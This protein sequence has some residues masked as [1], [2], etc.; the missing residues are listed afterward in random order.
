MTLPVYPDRKDSA[1]FTFHFQYFPPQKI[2]APTIII[3][4]GGPGVG[5]IDDWTNE[6]MNQFGLPSDAGKIF[7]DPRT[8]GCNEED[9]VVFPEDALTSEY[10]AQDILGMIRY[11]K[12]KNFILYGH[13]YGTVLATVTGSLGEKSGLKPS[14]LVLSGVIGKWIR[15]I[16]GTVF[17]G[18]ETEWKKLRKHIPASSLERFKSTPLPLGLSSNQWYNI[19]EE[20]LY[21]G[22]VMHRSELIHPLKESLKLLAHQ[23]VEMDLKAKDILIDHKIGIKEFNPD[24]V[25]FEKWSQRLFEVI[26]CGE[27]TDTEPMSELKN[28]EIVAYGDTCYQRQSLIRP[29]DSKDY[30]TTAP[31]FYFAGTAEAVTFY[32]QARRHFVNYLSSDRYF[33]TLF[34]GGHNRL[35][36]YFQDC[37]EQLWS[38]IAAEGSGFEKALN[39]CLVTQ[40][41]CSEINCS[42]QKIFEFRRS[43]SPR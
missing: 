4:P 16:K 18:L 11:L 9:E 15:G 8:V 3:I 5:L 14:A 34:E 19:I 33:V 32:Q 1:S 36:H 39:S 25:V 29:F 6:E 40:K 42:R 23:N 26:N 12:L 22:R 21:L 41:I 13:S 31:V 7:L 35:G 37:K 24:E 20:G 38:S 17:H 43:Q 28:G 2:S 10:L 27:L 30:L